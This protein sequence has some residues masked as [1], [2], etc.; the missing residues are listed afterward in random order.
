MLPLQ[1]VLPEGINHLY[2]LFQI[3]LRARPLKAKHNVYLKAD[4]LDVFRT[5]LD[6]QMMC[7]VKDVACSLQFL[8]LDFI[9]S[10]FWFIPTT[11]LFRFSSQSFIVVCNRIAERQP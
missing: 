5:T 10:L 4:I 9:V 8:S 7:N 11:L 6:R 2:E 3:I 1:G